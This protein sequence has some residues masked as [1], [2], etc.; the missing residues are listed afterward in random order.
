MHLFG[1]GPPK[2]SQ[3]NNRQPAR[4]APPCKPSS[5]DE[6]Q[7]PLLDAP[8]PPLLTV[9]HRLTSLTGLPGAMR[10]D[11]S[12]EESWSPRSPIG[13]REDMPQLSCELGEAAFPTH[14]HPPFPSCPS[15]QFPPQEW[16]LP[17]FAPGYSVLINCHKHEVWVM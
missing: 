9:N 17:G 15:S 11:D 10:W 14:T 7:T 5:S 3:N 8:H 13:H 2:K 6:D 1:G 16:P 4:C 12:Q